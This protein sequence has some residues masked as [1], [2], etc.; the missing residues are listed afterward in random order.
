MKTTVYSLEGKAVRD[1]ELD[2][3]VFGVRV[4]DSVMYYAVNNELAARR[5]GTASAKTR[6]EINGSTAK[7]WPRMRG[8]T[9]LYPAPA[10]V[11]AVASIE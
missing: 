6:S 8:T 2:D 1:I 5:V 11:S 3:D 4:N 7:P 9:T 10:R